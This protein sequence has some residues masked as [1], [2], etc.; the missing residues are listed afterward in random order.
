MTTA[1]MA[2]KYGP[3]LQ[4][5]ALREKYDVFISY[6]WGHYDSDF[7]RAMFDMFTNFDV[8]VGGGETN[9][10]CNSKRMVETFLDTK[11]LKEGRKFQTDFAAALTHSL[12]AVPILSV[13]ALGRMF[14]HNTQEVDN[15]LLEWIMML[16]CMTAKRLHSIF[17]VLFGTR[18]SAMPSSKAATSTDQPNVQGSGTNMTISNVF[19]E[20]LKSGIRVLDALP[21]V[22]PTATL[23]QVEALL[24]ANGLSCSTEFAKYTVHSVVNELLQFLCYK[25]WD[26]DASCLVEAVAEKAV[27]VLTTCDSAALDAVADI[28]PAKIS[29]AAVPVEVAPISVN[30]N[31]IAKSGSSSEAVASASRKLEDLSTAEVLQLMQVAGLNPLVE[32]FRTNVVSGLMLASCEEVDDLL[33]PEYG[34]PNKPLARGLLKK[35]VQWKESDVPAW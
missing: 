3:W 1:E 21:K 4:L 28:A 13:D 10:N 23:T 8:A 5:Y 30:T 17:P 31:I 24:K 9:N 6:R 15:V 18:V 19:T 12:L 14:D 7:T 11:R 33:L 25:A 22:A 35:I 29:T 20:K 16:E 2:S 27:Q 26:V 32:I 34:V